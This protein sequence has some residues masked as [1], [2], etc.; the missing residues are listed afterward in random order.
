MKKP[1]YQIYLSLIFLYI[2][3]MAFMLG[4]IWESFHITQSPSFLGLILGISS[5]TPFLLKRHFKK[6][7]KLNYTLSFLYKYRIISYILVTLII[8]VPISDSMYSLV[9][10]TFIFG[11][12]NLITL[13]T[14]ETYN[15][16]MVNSEIISSELASR[17]MQTVLQSGAFIGAII[18]GILL[19]NVDF[20]KFAL[21]ISIYELSINFIFL[22]IERYNVIHLNHVHKKNEE[23]CERLSKNIDINRILLLCIPL[24]IIGIHIS[25]FNISSTIIFQN[26]REWDPSIFGYVSSS[27]GVGAFVSSIFYLRKLSV[28]IASILLITFDILY[29]QS[30]NFLILMV[31]CFFIGFM[32]NSLRI[33]I[34]TYLLDISTTPELS[35]KMGEYSAVSYVLF[36]SIGSVIVGTALSE[37]LLGYAFSIYVLPLTALLLFIS[38]FFVFNRRPK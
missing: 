7:S 6:I 30:E 31:S 19:S 10:I 24:G 15:S 33:G 37:R 36:Q 34:R 12:I 28:Y 13:T 38:I 32:I 35:Q 1:M 2:S 18:S 8:L 16:Y 11:M 20:K 23:G 5:L 22:I 9:A 3:D 4:I 14:Y 29:T 25:S 27:A 17:I 21:I 26:I